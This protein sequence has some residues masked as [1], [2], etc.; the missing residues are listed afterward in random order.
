MITESTTNENTDCIAKTVAYVARA[1]FDCRKVVR[2]PRVGIRRVMM[3]QYK[4]AKQI[5][6]YGMQNKIDGFR[7]YFEPR[8]GDSASRISPVQT[9]FMS[10]LCCVRFCL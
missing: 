5:L 4:V 9:N 8:N 2:W 6:T 7:K 1:N 10:Q 3:R